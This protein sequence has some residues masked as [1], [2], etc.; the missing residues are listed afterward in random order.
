MSS[1]QVGLDSA[2]NEGELPRSGEA[3][4]HHQMALINAF[5]GIVD[6]VQKGLHLDD[7]DLGAIRHACISVERETSRWIRPFNHVAGLI[8]YFPIQNCPGIRAVFYQ[9]SRKILDQ[10]FSLFRVSDYI[11]PPGP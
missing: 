5:Y 9:R 2:Y 8:H 4:R 10:R 6:L 11:R 1:K 7:R 3:G